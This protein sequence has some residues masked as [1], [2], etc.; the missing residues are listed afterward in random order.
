MEGSFH[1]KLQAFKPMI[2]FFGM[3]NSP[4]T[5]QV[6][7]DSILGDMKKK[8][9]CIVYM[10]NIM[11][12][13][14]ILEKLHKATLEPF[15]II[16]K[17]DLFFKAEKCVFTQTKVPFLGMIIKHNKISMDPAKVKG[18]ADWPIPTNVKELW[19]FLGFGNFYQKFIT[20]YAELAHDLYVLLQKG[21]PFIWA[22]P[23]QQ[24]FQH[25][26]NRFSE[27]PVL[28]IPDLMRPFQI[29]SDTSKHATGALLTQ[30]DGNGDHHPCTFIS[31]TFSLAKRNYEIYNWE[32]L[33]LVCALTEWHHYIHGS[34]H[35]TT[36][37]SDH[38]NLTY[39]RSPQKLN[40]RQAH[41]HL[42][43]SEF[44]LELVHVP[45]LKLY[46]AD[47]LSCHPN[48]IPEGDND[49]EDVTML[50]DSLFINLIDTELQWQITKSTN[51]DTNAAEVLKLLL[52]DGS[53]ISKMT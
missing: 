7:M 43:I 6:M 18:I 20:Q 24:G 28:M 11:I 42:F 51:L 13:A 29:E 14:D 21:V 1:H 2:M 49:N 46:Q 53:W 25:L 52:E 44:D 12:Y 17:N 48:H 32:L 34:P 45:G 22:E 41:W 50:P 23:Q 40:C 3:C 19:A 9:Y 16:N 33:A 35:T 8:G 39:W 31:K 5:F 4:A 38:K 36:A 26:K 27:E 10:D 15:D 37:L 30:M 47:A